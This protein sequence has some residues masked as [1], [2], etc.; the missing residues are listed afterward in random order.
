MTQPGETDG[1]NVFDHVEA[2][3]KHVGSNIIDYVI[4]NNE[5]LPKQVLNL[6]K[7]DGAEQVLLDKKQVEGLKDMGIKCIEKNMVEIK[8]NYIRHDAK[9]ISNIIIE[10]ALNHSCM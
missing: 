3:E 6:Y 7:H 1:Y 9:Y 5:M 10:L 4:V 2:I 8:N